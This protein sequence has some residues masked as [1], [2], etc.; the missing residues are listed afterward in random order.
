[1]TKELSP[2]QLAAQQH[3]YA[4]ASVRPELED[5]IAKME[6]TAKANVF[7]LIRQKQLTP[8]MAIAAW[9]ELYS[10]QRLNKRIA[11]TAQGA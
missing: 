9:M 5:M 3:A 11:D 4:V 6:A 10:Y 2:Q 1:M 7:E 8:D